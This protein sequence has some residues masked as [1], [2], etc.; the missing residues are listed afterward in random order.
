M[1]VRA[2][3]ADADLQRRAAADGWQLLPGAAVDVP[4]GQAG[5]GRR[6]RGA[7]NTGFVQNSRGLRGYRTMDHVRSLS[8]PSEVRHAADCCRFHGRCPDTGRREAHLRVVGDSLN[9]IHRFAQA[10]RRDRLDPRAARGRRCLRGRCRSASHR[11]PGGVRRQLRTGQPAPD[12]RAVRLP[13]QRRARARDRR[14]HSQQRDRH[15]LLPGD[16]SGEACSRNAATTSNSCPRARSCRRSSSG[17][18]G[19]PSDSKGVGVVVIPGDVALETIDA[20]PP[21]VWFP[22]LPSWCRRRADLDRLADM[23]NAASRVTLMCGAGC[24]GAHDEVV[25]LAK[26]LQVA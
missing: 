13:P 11:P 8:V 12:Q 21:A 2:A 26:R 3:G 10:H 4:A 9:G 25:E 6:R 19:R 14:A 18:C 23:L 7:L 20:T 24:A 1:M 15:R 17:R 22:R 5:D 16:A